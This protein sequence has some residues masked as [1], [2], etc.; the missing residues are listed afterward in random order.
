MRK[1]FSYAAGCGIPLLTALVA[2]TLIAGPEFP[3]SNY[4]SRR[5]TLRQAIET[6]LQQNPDI[7]RA[8]QEIE[9]TKGLVVEVRAQALPQVEAQAV[10]QAT[11][12][13]LRNRGFGG[14]STGDGDGTGATPTPTASATPTATPDGGDGVVS[15]PT[16]TNNSYNLRFQV[17]QLIFAGGAVRGQISAAMFTRDSSYFALR[18]TVDQVISTV[19]TQFYQV[20]LNRALIGVQEQSIRLLESQLQDQQNRFEAGT[21][22]RFNVLQAQVA[23]SNQRPELFTARNNLRIAQLQLAKTLGLAFD[24]R[25]GESPPLEIV[26]D[27]T[28]APRQMPLAQAIEVA[29]ERRAFLKQQRAAI[30][31]QR[32]QIRIALAGYLPTVRASGGYEFQSSPFSDNIRDVSSG[33]TVGATGNWP[34]FDGFQTA[35]RVKQARAALATAEINYD[36]AVRQVEL[37]VQQAFSNL[38]QGSE[39]I[40]SQTENVGQAD[41]A[42]RL[43][44]ARLS[45]GAGTQLEVLNS[46][47][48]VTRAQ[49]V[50]LQALFS[51]A[52]AQAEFDR[53]TASDTEYHV[54][55]DDPLRGRETRTE[56]MTTKEEARRAK[57][58][59][60]RPPKTTTTTTRATTRTTRPS[61]FSK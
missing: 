52:S 27:L 19:R 37:E 10:F 33:Y 43:A 25:R 49:S 47:V 48:E 17:S 40:R 21:V 28:Y 5:F 58:D 22:P 34:I 4:G 45:A 8:R 50:R 44:S 53:V 32:D 38:Q 59:D 39:L 30:F 20:A 29:T 46:R 11:D 3:G 60:L 42:L 1:F 51:Y 16:T 2:S 23:L 13:N 9:R 54:V 7:L 61:G 55:F 12:P 14:F 24:P 26:G 56:K 36:D 57:I 15:G 6:A 31:S 41:E 18:N 35:G